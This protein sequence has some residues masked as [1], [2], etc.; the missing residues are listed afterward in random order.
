MTCYRCFLPDLA[1]F[2]GSNCTA[3]QL[4]DKGM[5]LTKKRA[6]NLKISQTSPSAS[7]GESGIRTHGGVSPT[8]A[9]QACSL[10]HSDISPRR[11]DSTTKK[12][13][14]MERSGG[15]AEALQGCWRG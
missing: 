3:P 12:L 7:N 5:S 9:F 15:C 10:N 2:A 1:G 8:H 11:S 14:S 6:G 13:I 4:P